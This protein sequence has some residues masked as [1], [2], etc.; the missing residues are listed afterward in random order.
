MTPDQKDAMVDCVAQMEADIDWTPRRKANLI[1]A[2]RS[3][4]P[5]TASGK[6]TS[7]RNATKHG[8]LSSVP[9]LP[10]ED[11]NEWQAHLDGLRENLK[12]VGYHEDLLTFRYAL[13][14]WRLRRIVSYEVAQAEDRAT[15]DYFGKEG[16]ALPL[17][18]S[19]MDNL[20]RY[21]VACDRLGAATL[22]ELRRVQ[23]ERVQ[24]EEDAINDEYE[25]LPLDEKLAL[26]MQQP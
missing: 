26:H 10:G 14:L 22:Q 8:A 16:N 2:K 17:T 23:A 6:A 12:P 4:G 9:V 24:A 21:E 11:A 25:A 18:L 5:K 13:Q 19:S 3:T 1:N 15:K 7:A 20:I